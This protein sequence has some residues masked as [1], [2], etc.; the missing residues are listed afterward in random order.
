MFLHY[1]HLPLRSASLSSLPPSL[2]KK[3]KKPTSS[4]P[5]EK[6]SGGARSAEKKPVTGLLENVAVDKRCTMHVIRK[7]QR[8]FSFQSGRALKV[9]L[10]FLS[11]CSRERERAIQPAARRPEKFSRTCNDPRKRNGAVVPLR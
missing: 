8:C 4:S 3:E 11:A 7:L 9:K 5:G 6:W 2:P 10:A 1:T